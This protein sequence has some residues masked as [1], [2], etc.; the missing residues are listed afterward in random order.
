MF[1]DRGI[2][3]SMPECADV[4]ASLRNGYLRF[5]LHGEKLKGIW[6][7]RRRPENLQNKSN[8]VWDLVKEPDA[9]ARSGRPGDILE[10]APN[11]VSTGRTLEEIGHEWNERRGKKKSDAVLFDM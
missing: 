8:P 6:T 11:S 5:T 7:L 2:W 10:E 9:F 3:E 4:E 1:W